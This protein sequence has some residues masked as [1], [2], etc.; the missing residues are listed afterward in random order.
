MNSPLK[1]LDQ[2]TQRQALQQQQ[3]F[4]NGI[5]ILSEAQK[6]K[7]WDDLQELIAMVEPPTV[8]QRKAKDKHLRRRKKDSWSPEEPLTLATTYADTFIKIAKKWQKTLYKAL[9]KGDATIEKEVM[10]KLAAAE[11]TVKVIKQNMQEFFDDHFGEQQL[12]KS[13]SQ[14][15]VSFATQIYCDNP[16]LVVTVAEKSDV[17]RGQLDYYGNVVKEDHFYAIVE[18]F[19][20]NM[21]LVSPFDGNK[22]MYIVDIIK[23]TDYMSFVTEMHK[24]AQESS[25]NQDVV[26]ID[27]ERINYKMDTLFGLNDDTATKV[28]DEL[29]LQFAWDEE[30]LQ[31]N[32]FRRHLYE[33][34]N[35][36]NLNYGGFD[37]DSMSFNMPLGPGDVNH[38][39]DNID[40]LDRLKLVDAICNQD[41]PFFDIK[42]LRTLVKEYYAG[43][44][45]SAWWKGMGFEE[46]TLD[47]MRLK[48]KEFLR[49]RFRKDRATAASEGKEEFEFDG[50][51][52]ATG[53]TGEGTEKS[54]PTGK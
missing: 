51:V 23:I 11:Q 8:K 47:L 48:Q 53:F 46:G 7:N 41:N 37:F 34:P 42:L 38:W 40:D 43:R 36:Q 28:Q 24:Q 44:A 30:I 9:E 15:Q 45:E 2:N 32:S 29:V 3:M 31:G 22:D 20:G 18:D 5:L 14:Q 52:Y 49:M 39:S 6:R 21:V 19:Y 10:L 50:K 33:H 12:S 17:K 4:D 1:Q 25:K 26:K 13:V 35:I 54:D 27:L 16:E